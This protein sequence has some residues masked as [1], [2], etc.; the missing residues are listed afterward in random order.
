M[1]FSVVSII[2]T[3][4]LSFS[5]SGN[6]SFSGYVR[7]KPNSVTKSFPEP[8]YSFSNKVA[9]PIFPATSKSTRKGDIRV[10]MGNSKLGNASRQ[11]QFDTISFKTASAVRQ[12]AVVVDMLRANQVVF[13]CYGKTKTIRRG[14]VQFN[15]IK[16]N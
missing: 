16:V 14:C 13:V 11:V 4:N 5:A 10:Y 1:L 6:V 8:I 15:A 7:P 2:F 12:Q 3:S 9:L